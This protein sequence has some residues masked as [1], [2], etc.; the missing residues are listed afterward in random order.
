[1]APGQPGS[2]VLNPPE[3]VPGA[4]REP[5]K[6][7]LWQRRPDRSGDRSMWVCAALYGVAGYGPTEREAYDAWFA[8]NALNIDGPR[9]A[10]RVRSRA[11]TWDTP[12]LNPL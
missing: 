1:M 12:C 7:H 2:T 5:G 6:P 8:G 9:G 10:L 3:S 11:H 4:L